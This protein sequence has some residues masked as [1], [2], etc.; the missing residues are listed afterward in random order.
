MS[1]RML[2]EALFKT[3]EM[4]LS[5]DATAEQVEQVCY[6]SEQM[7]KDDKNY[8]DMEKAR[9]VMEFE[10]QDRIERA[11]ITLASTIIELED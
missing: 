4:V 7:I 1:N 11:T 3:L 10:R 6:L 5:G 2:K 8:I 9:M